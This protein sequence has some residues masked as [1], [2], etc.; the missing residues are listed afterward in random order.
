MAH[1]TVVVVSVLHHSNGNGG[2]TYLQNGSALYWDKE[3]TYLVDDQ[4]LSWLDSLPKVAERPMTP[5]E[6]ATWA[7]VLYGQNA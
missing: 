4:T 1:Q 3:S 6:E 7:Q 2:I 5:E